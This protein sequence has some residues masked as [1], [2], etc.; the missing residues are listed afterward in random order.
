MLLR[1]V[2]DSTMRRHAKANW[3]DYVYKFAPD[4][5]TLRQPSFRAFSV[6]IEALDV[7]RAC[8][9]AQ[10]EPSTFLYRRLS[11][12]FHMAYDETPGGIPYLD[13]WRVRLV[14]DPI[15]EEEQ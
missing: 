1:R 3:S 12:D 11:G 4:Q 8:V 6:I 2:G 15:P 10:L 5:Y 14:R 9:L 13:V 7:K